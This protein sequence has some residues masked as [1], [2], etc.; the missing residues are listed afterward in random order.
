MGR[1]FI[2]KENFSLLS[3]LLY[4]REKH[5]S[6]VVIEGEHHKQQ[7]LEVCHDDCLSGH[8]SEDRTLERMSSTAWWVGS[9]LDT[10]VY[11]ASC[12]RC[13]K[14][15]KATGKKV[16]D[17]YRKIEEP[18]YPWEIINMDF[19]TGLPPAGIENF[20]CCLVIV[21]R[22]SKRTRCLPCHREATAMDVAL[23]IFGRGL[24]SDVGLPKGIISDR[25]P[26]FTSEFWKGLMSLM[27]TKLQFSTAYHPMTDGLAERMIQTL[28]DM[29]RRYCAFGLEFKDKDG[30]HS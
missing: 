15:N 14:A 12:D 26:K 8:L 2:K 23:F 18:T 27:G 3:G 25:D 28:E 30:L 6:V 7:L 1:A 9:K 17:F 4:F 16:L 11:V 22:F 13:Q 24:I 5:T 19:V 10:Q 20:N 29:I 21:D